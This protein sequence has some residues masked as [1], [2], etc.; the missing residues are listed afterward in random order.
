MDKPDNYKHNYFMLI[1]T[2]KRM[3]YTMCRRC[4]IVKSCCGGCRLIKMKLN[5]IKKNK[6]YIDFDDIEFES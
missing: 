6:N 1:K 5:D 4:P 3:E 2:I